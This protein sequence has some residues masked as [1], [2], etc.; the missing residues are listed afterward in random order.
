MPIK[1]LRFS[2]LKRMLTPSKRKTVEF[3]Q[4]A[5]YLVSAF[6]RCVMNSISTSLSVLQVVNAIQT[7]PSDDKA[8][9]MLIF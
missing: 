2:N 7:S 9:I 1:E 4:S 8:V 3:R 6:A 5:D